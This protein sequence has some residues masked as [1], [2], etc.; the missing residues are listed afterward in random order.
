MSLPGAMIDL[1]AVPLAL[2]VPENVVVNGEL[3]I[4]DAGQLHLLNPVAALVWQCCD[5]TASVAELAEEFSNTFGAPAA[6]VQ[7][8]VVEVVQ[9]LAQRGLVTFERNDLQREQHL[10][11]PIFLE[12]ATACAGC[13]DGPGFSSHIHIAMGET[14]VSVGADL[15]LADAVCD[16]FASYVVG[17]DDS[18]GE[19]PPY[20]GLII[21]TEPEPSGVIPV[22]RLH[23]GPTMLARSRSP[24]RA[25]RALAAQIATHAIFPGF[26]PI[27]ALAIGRNGRAILVAP[28]TNRVAYDHDVAQASLQVS[29]IPT[30]RVS[31]DSKTILVGAD[32]LGL[33]LEPLLRLAAL[34][35]IVATNQ[36]VEP[37][38]LAWGVH[39]LV[40]MGVRSASDG[41][42]AL[43]EFG[44]AAT[45]WFDPDATVDALINLIDSVPIIGSAEP[46]MI[47]DYLDQT[48]R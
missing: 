26:V 16:A 30:A 46:S 31:L 17:R 10:D 15:E 1:D 8:D 39:E 23:R 33:E 19:T 38:P 11:V 24:E 37:R 27:D 34:R 44:P 42:Q 20:Y 36:D 13:G 35:T 48:Q 45:S 32:V 43:A 28:P 3:V 7:G 6:I 9:D 5:G 29:D 25:V 12:P 18:P 41:A 40:A 4:H 21:P 22:C 47:A 14:I 2:S